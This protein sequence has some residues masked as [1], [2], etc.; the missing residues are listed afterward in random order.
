M[1]DI[2][3]ILHAEC[4]A[5]ETGQ[6]PESPSRLNAIWDALQAAPFPA[7][8]AWLTPEPATVADILRVH[9]PALVDHIRTMAASGGGMIGL[10]TVVSRHSY[11]AALIAAGG[12]AL[13]V[14]TAC[15]QPGSRAFALVRPPGHHATP[16]TAMGFCLFNNVA[17][18]T[19]VALDEL[20]L[21]R[22]AIV[23]FD[24]HHGNGTQAAFRADGRVL[25]CS[26]HQ[27]P[28]YPGSGRASEIGEGAG[29]GLTL[30]LPLPPGVGDIGYRAAFAQVIEPALRRFQPELIVVSAG[31]DAHWADPLAD[32]RVSTT[33]FV[34]MTQTLSQLADEL[35]GGRL[36][37]CL[38][39]GYD[40][41]A[42]ATSVVAV[43][44]ALA[45]G[46]PRDRLG[47]PPGGAIDDVSSVLDRVRGLHRL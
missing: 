26:L 6:H 33:G 5:H 28:L 3:L 7:H 40:L 2:A 18:A 36:A 42:L 21:A 25:F 27:F 22:V 13:A 1:N 23:D 31:F 34:E 37:L 29:Q 46:T 19:K 39:G 47:P 10:D 35:C 30:N 4:L 17:I 45:G 8:V 9:E 11:H 14:R 15:G 24:V 41:D 32:M 44:T 12:A 38:E 43:V 16:D 20:G